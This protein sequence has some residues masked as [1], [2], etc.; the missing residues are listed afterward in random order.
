MLQRV[1][2]F[3]CNYWLWIDVRCSDVQPQPDESTVGCSVTSQVKYAPDKP[4]D[5]FI[6]QGTPHAKN[7]NQCETYSLPEHYTVVVA[8]KDLQ[9][10]AI[11]FM[12]FPSRSRFLPQS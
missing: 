9:M 8:L 5:I 12:G 7:Q 10:S 1:E 6:N 2:Y 11:S 3:E 4:C